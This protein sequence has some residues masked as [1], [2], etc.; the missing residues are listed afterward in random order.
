LKAKRILQLEARARKLFDSGRTITEFDPRTQ[1]NIH[2][3][4]E[5]LQ[6]RALQMRRSFGKLKTDDQNPFKAAEEQL[7]EANKHLAEMEKALALTETE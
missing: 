7:K 1:R 5:E 2:V 3:G 6:D 4:A